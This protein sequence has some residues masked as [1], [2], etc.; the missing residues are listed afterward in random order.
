MRKLHR[1]L[2]AGFV[3][4]LTYLIPLIQLPTAHAGD[5]LKPYVVFILDSSGSMGTVTNAGPTS[6]GTSDT[7]LNHAKCAINKISNSYGDMVLALGRF[8]QTPTGTFATSCTADCAVTGACTADDTSFELLT[9]LVD[10]TNAGPASFTDNVCT[11]CA[12]SGAG[13]LEVYKPGGNTPLG[14]VLLGARRYFQ[15][16]QATDSSVIWPSTAAG[17][18]PI[19]N[20]PTK[21]V[22]LTPTQQC[23]PYIT[24]LL[25]DG[26]E[27]CNGNAPAAATSLLTTPLGGKNYRILTKP[28]GFG[29]SPGNANI[30][31]VAHA[32]GAPDVAGVNEGSY[33][34]NEEELQ[35]A[36]SKIIAD[37]V[38]S[39]VC[40]NLD[41]D[42]DTRIDEDFPSKGGACNNGQLGICRGTG[43][44][45]CRADGTGTQCNITAPGATA[46]SESCNNL[47]DDCDGLVDEG[48]C[49]ACGDVEI[50]N[51]ID[52]DC[53]GNIDEALTR[54]CGSGVG[55][56][57]IGVETC[58]AGMWGGCTGVNP[59]AETCDGRDNDCDGTR[60]GIA[61]SCST[62]PGG[63]NP[64]QGI[65]R[66]GIRTCPPGGAGTFGACLGEVQPRTE[67]CNLLDDDCD[68]LTDESTG[69]ARCS[70]TCGVGTTVCVNGQLI[71]NAQ[72]AMSDDTC[73]GNDDDCD[74]NIDEN[75][76]DMGACDGGGTIC[77]GVLVCQGGSYQ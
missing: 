8:K 29:I 52:D 23:R 76:L 12:S 14:G 26:D 7:R 33:A 27:T 3:V 18:S 71:C 47:D 50:C 13:S 19:F 34:A 45:G 61:Q 40:N 22:F 35:L 66:P 10:G 68:G 48:V 5:P 43:V 20:D 53:D 4:A 72:P 64:N 51:N 73:D 38:R 46:G 67:A 59:T 32:G 75:A 37:S 49:G 1:R 39:E 63:V 25:T 70:T 30:E 60:D 74:G 54:P 77:G 58:A 9:S 41:D 6:C 57:R 69:G 16:L 21:N 65:C 28:I 24:I 44:F 42:C 15:G 2:A 62:L 31:A 56:C 11:T 17:F 36:V 55:D